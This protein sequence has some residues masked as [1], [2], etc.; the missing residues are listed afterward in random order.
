M[1]SGTSR[2]WR[3]PRVIEA[4]LRQRAVVHAIQRLRGRQVPLFRETFA[5]RK[6]GLCLPG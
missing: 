6:L 3:I 5:M 1:M 4:R 2:C